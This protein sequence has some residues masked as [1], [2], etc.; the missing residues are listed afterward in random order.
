MEGGRLVDQSNRLYIYMEMDQHSV[1]G[2]NTELVFD[3][4]DTILDLIPL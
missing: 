3:I 2:G 1:P 4:F